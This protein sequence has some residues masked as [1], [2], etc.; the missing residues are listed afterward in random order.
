MYLVIGIVRV[1][2]I[3][4][5]ERKCWLSLLCVFRFEVHSGNNVWSSLFQHNSFFTLPRLFVVKWLQYILQ[6]WSIQLI[7]LKI[8]IYREN[9]GN[10]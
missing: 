4:V 2:R 6:K 9:S 3:S 7:L 1:I 8:D 5:Y 10:Q